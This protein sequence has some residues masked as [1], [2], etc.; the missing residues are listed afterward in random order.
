MPRSGTTLVEQIVTSCPAIAAG[1]E[2]FFWSN[3]ASSRGIV[4][5]TAL[6]SQA[7]HELAAEYLSLLCRIGPS[8]ARVTDKQTFDFQQLGLIH[9][10]LPNARIIHCDRHP[11][12]TCLSMYFTFFNGRLPFVSS[13]ADLAFAYRQHMRIMDH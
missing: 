6:R 2:L 13:K 7:A 8:A 11:I 12:D 4:E 10:L 9:L 3:R 5:A 1:E